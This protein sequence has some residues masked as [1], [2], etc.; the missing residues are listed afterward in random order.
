M[1]LSD[2]VKSIFVFWIKFTFAACPTL[3][4]SVFQEPHA[5]QFMNKKC[6][7]SL[8]Q[9]KQCSDYNSLSK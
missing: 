2:E 1:H 9:A 5:T 8:E 6:L 4:S 7:V 3:V